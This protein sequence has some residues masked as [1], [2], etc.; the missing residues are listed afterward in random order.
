MKF[1]Q[2]AAL[3]AAMLCAAVAPKGAEAEA[4][5]ARVSVETQTMHVYLDGQLRYEWPVSTA[6]AGKYTPR[7]EWQP[8]WLSRW[9]RSSLY[10]NAPMYF[11]IFYDGD[12]AIHATDAVS[13]LGRPASAGCVRLHEDNAALLFAMVQEQGMENMRVVVVD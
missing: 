10:N 3:A 4:I 8:Q 6:R 7:G 9:H 1:L 13:R 11:A 5:V 2:R 12:Y